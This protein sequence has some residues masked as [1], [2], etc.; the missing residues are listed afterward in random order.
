[1]NGLS[2]AHVTDPVEDQLSIEQGHVTIL[3]QNMAE[4]AVAE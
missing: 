3:P 2:G 4:L 1:M